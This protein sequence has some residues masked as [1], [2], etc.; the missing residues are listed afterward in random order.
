MIRP[1]AT[2]DGAAIADL[3]VELGYEATRQIV[4]VRLGQVVQRRHETVLVAEE[5]GEVV[6]WIHLVDRAFL[7]EDRGGEIE[8]MVVAE[9]RRRVGI[10]RALVGAAEDWAVARGLQVIRLRSRDNRED[11]HAFYQA[12]GFVAV[13][14]SVVFARDVNR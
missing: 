13:K 14:A 11:A 2:S 3:I 4:D 10:G 9:G 12:L 6:G 7:H 8:S 5:A 1:A